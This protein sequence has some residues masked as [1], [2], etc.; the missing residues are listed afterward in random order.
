MAERLKYHFEPGKGWIN[1]PNGLI[2]YKGKYHAFFQHNP[3][4]PKWD[5]MHWGHAVSGDLIHWEELPIALYPDKPYENLGGCYSGSAIEKDGKLYL[6][7]TSVSKELGQTQSL[8][9]SDDGIH[10]EKYSGNPVIAKFPDDGSHD[11]RDP[12]VTE[13]NGTYYM[14]VGSGKNRVGKV[15]IFTSTDLLNWRY[16]GVLFESKKY[17]KVFECP[18]FF[19]LGDRF[20]LMFSQMGRKYNSTHFIVGDFDGEKFTPISE[21]TSEAGPQF[22]APQTF[23]DNNGRR[24]MIG[25]LYDWNK[26]LDKGADYAGALSIPREL[27]LKNDMILNYPVEEAHGLLTNY[28]EL[29]TVHGNSVSIKKFSP[30]IRLKYDNITD[31]AVLRDTKTIEVFLNKGEKSFSY[32]FGK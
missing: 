32:W 31:I 5:K 15:L 11:F 21:C 9:V 27:T 12:K 16:G 14:V 3:Y 24:I 1:D 17:G 28:D 19:P 13:I 6:F 22:Y 2:Q 29:L 30:H 26:K 8:A 20:V 18:D 23:C 4:A 7:Y 10:F 25:W